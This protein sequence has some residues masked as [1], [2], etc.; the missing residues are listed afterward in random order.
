MTNIAK[1]GLTTTGLLLVGSVG[2]ALGEEPLPLRLPCGPSEYGLVPTTPSRA[3]CHGTTN[4]DRHPL[5][6]RSDSAGRT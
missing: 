6:A 1:H 4:V 5:E 2:I 3:C